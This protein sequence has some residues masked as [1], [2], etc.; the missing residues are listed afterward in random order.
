MTIYK[1]TFFSGKMERLQHQ[2][3]LREAAHHTATL[4]PGNCL[5]SHGGKSLTS[6]SNYPPDYKHVV[7]T[8]QITPISS[9]SRKALA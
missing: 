6:L 2:L 5:A 3:A 9:C 8:T 7:Y 4:N 1:T